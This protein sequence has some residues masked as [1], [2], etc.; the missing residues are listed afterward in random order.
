M[1]ATEIFLISTKVI[2]CNIWVYNRWDILVKEYR[3][4]HYL[5]RAEIYVKDRK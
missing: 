2:F 1:S 5:E 4:V 3:N